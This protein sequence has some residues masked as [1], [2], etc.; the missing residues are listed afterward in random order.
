[1]I[2]KKEFLLLFAIPSRRVHVR[3]HRKGIIPNL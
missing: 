3:R 2:E 1:M